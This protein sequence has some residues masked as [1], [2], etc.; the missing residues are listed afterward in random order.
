MWLIGHSLCKFVFCA[1][2]EILSLRGEKN[3]YCKNNDYTKNKSKICWNR[4][5]VSLRGAQLT[6]WMMLL[7]RNRGEKLCPQLTGD[8]NWFQQKHFQDHWF[9]KC[10]QSWALRSTSKEQVSFSSSPNLFIY[11]WIDTIHSSSWPQDRFFSSH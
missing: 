1:V 2:E 3:N 8:F 11:Y 4:S 10:A 5:R 6:F 7:T 9:V